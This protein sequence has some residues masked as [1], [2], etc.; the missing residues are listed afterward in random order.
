[1]DRK[2]FIVLIN[3][4]LIVA[5]ALAVTTIEVYA[6]VRACVNNNSGEIKIVDA[7]ALCKNNETLVE[8]ST[9]TAVCSSIMVHG[10]GTVPGPLSCEDD[11]G[12]E[13]PQR[14][15]KRVLRR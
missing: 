7:N 3:M 1:M 15:Y 6:Q 14:H 9:T 11:H 2:F 13:H 4:M 8:W 5:L 10:G 12:P